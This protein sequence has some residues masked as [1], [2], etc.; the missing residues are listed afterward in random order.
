MGGEREGEREISL[1]IPW[2]ARH[3]L[4]SQSEEVNFKTFQ[5]ISR[6]EKSVTD[7]HSTHTY[8]HDYMYM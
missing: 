4:T 5:R 1:I 8:T 7:R 6:E 3:T 2:N